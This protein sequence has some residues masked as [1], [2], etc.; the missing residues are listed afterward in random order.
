MVRTQ[1][2]KPIIILELSPSSFNKQPVIRQA[3]PGKLRFVE[4]K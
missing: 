4:M 2:A 1:G 3:L